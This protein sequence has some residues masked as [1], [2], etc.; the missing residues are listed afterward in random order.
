MVKTNLGN[1]KGCVNR[2][3][4]YVVIVGG[5]VANKGAQSMTFQIIKEI[6]KH[7]PGKEVVVFCNSKT[8]DVPKMDLE[9]NVKV[10]PFDAKDILY[11]IG[12]IKKVA[13]VL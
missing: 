1:R 11:F 12:G 7:M 8:N 6:R 4:E 5:G 10:V 2:D 3:M 9:Y 13:S